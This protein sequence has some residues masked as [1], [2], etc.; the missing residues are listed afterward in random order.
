MAQNVTKMS[1]TCTQQPA[2]NWRRRRPGAAAA[3]WRMPQW[4]RYPV[5]QEVR[6]KGAHRPPLLYVVVCPHIVVLDKVQG[7]LPE[8]QRPPALDTLCSG[9]Q[10]APSAWASVEPDL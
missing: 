2:S 7:R 3:A 10:P 9:V 5:T 6:T 8:G 4:Q 1:P